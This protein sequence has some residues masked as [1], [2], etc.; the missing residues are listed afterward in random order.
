[1]IRKCRFEE[2]KNL[3]TRAE[4]KC[5]IAL[6]I[7]ERKKAELRSALSELDSVRAGW[8]HIVKALDLAIELMRREAEQ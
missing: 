7:N 5:Y 1:M 2:D 4:M 3:A 8:E 6:L